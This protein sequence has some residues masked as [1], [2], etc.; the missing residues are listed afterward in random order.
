[1]YYNTGLYYYDPYSEQKIDIAID[2]LKEATLIKVKLEKESL[3]LVVH[4]SCL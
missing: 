4:I 3:I 1:M 2:V